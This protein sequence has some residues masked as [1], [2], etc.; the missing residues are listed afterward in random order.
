MK[1]KKQIYVLA[2]LV[3]IIWGSIVYQV[4]DHFRDEGGEWYQN[5]GK[6]FNDEVLKPES[7]S[8]RL[9]A[10]YS[11]PFLRELEKDMD[12]TDETVQATRSQSNQ[13]G[14][15]RRSVR[16]VR[17]TQWP[18]I[19]YGGVVSKTNTGKQILLVNVNAKDYFASVNDTVE[20]VIIK[21][22]Y[23]DSIITQFMDE[24]KTIPINQ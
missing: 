3:L 23:A 6:Q 9:R 20:K 1:N 16:R 7:T 17:T 13:I 21:Q 5:P 2:P 18:E 10:D 14:G 11:D 8:F 12:N 4:I 22:A 24:V 15:R 19:V